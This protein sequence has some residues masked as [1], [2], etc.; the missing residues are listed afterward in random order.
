MDSEKAWK[1]TCSFPATQTAW[2][3]DTAKKHHGGSVSALMQELVDRAMQGKGPAEPASPTILEDL[4]ERLLHPHTEDIVAALH[5]HHIRNQPK[6]L[7][8][9]LVGLLRYLERR[10]DPDRNVITQNPP[11]LIGLDEASKLLTAKEHTRT[12]AISEMLL[13][14]PEFAPGRAVAERAARFGRT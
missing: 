12:L 13:A 7:S 9:A 3:Q 1:T 5:K 2:I 14:I 10:S 11:V 6:L 8:L 4:F